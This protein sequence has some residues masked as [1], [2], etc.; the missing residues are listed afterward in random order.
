MDPSRFAKLKESLD[1][2][3]QCQFCGVRT[4][5]T[6]YVAFMRDHDRPQGGRCL[7]ASRIYSPSI[8]K[9]DYAKHDDCDCMGCLP[10]T[11]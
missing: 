5:M 10:H 1:K 7:K 3:V 9:P 2:R 8:R 11:Y 6:D 4:W